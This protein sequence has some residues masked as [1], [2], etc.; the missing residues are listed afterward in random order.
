MCPQAL[1]IEAS[2]IPGVIG[3]SL[4]LYLDFRELQDANDC[5]YI[6]LDHRSVILQ[7]LNNNKGNEG[8]K[9]GRS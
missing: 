3:G 4:M 8:R 7:T 5:K 6:H 9:N 1:D 2:T